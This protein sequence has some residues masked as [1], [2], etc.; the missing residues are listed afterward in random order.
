MSNLLRLGQV[1]PQ[2]PPGGELLPV[3]E[4][5]GHF[6]AGVPR[7]QRGAVLHELLGSLHVGK[8]E[9]MLANTQKV[10]PATPDY[11]HS[12]ARART[13]TSFP[14]SGG[15]RRHVECFYDTGSRRTASRGRRTEVTGEALLNCFATRKKK[16]KTTLPKTPSN[17]TPAHAINVWLWL[18]FY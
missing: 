5:V 2:L 1:D 8:G 14:T 11:T 15:A 4:V 17:V 3:T 18:L 7:H 6:L 9:A 13:D 12:N 16:S 10:C